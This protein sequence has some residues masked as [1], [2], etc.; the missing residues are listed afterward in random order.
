MP[1]IYPSHPRVQ[2]RGTR[3]EAPKVRAIAYSSNADRLAW[4]EK[5][6]A[7]TYL[8]IGRSISAVISSLIEDPAPR[9]QILVIDL[10]ALSPGE[11]LELHAIREA[12]WTGTIIG[13]GKVPASL[14]HSL[15]IDKILRFPLVDHT[16]RDT[17]AQIRY[18]AP[19]TRLP[20][21]ADL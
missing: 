3:Q 14:R 5:E 8:T 17:I 1:V 19:T 6:L 12:G 18:D 13:L 9:P 10:D 2:A 7:A 4:I 16:L 21:F 15:N 11:I 20:V